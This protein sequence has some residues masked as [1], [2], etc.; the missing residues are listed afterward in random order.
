MVRDFIR[1]VPGFANAVKACL[2]VRTIFV[3]VMAVYIHTSLSCDIGSRA[4]YYMQFTPIK[5]RNN[6]ARIMWNNTS[7]ACLESS[8]ILVTCSRAL[9]ITIR[10]YL[11]QSGISTYIHTISHRNTNLVSYH[12]ARMSHFQANVHTVI[13]RRIHPMRTMWYSCPIIELMCVR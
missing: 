10:M 12:I 8:N 6:I 2:I 7:N 13:S 1:T 4:I 5:W 9:V 11:R 3:T